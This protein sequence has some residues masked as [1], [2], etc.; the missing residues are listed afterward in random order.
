ML[1][2][3]FQNALTFLLIWGQNKFSHNRK[4]KENRPRI[5]NKNA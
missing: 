4:M 2:N 1:T 3:F 5:T